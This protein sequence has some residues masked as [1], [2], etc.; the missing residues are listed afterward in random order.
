M[1]TQVNDTLIS[2]I[3]ELE[4]TD[5]QQLEELGKN[6]SAVQILE[7]LSL[8]ASK[9]KQFIEKLF[10]IFHSLPSTIFREILTT[11]EPEQYLLLTQEVL[12]EA[13]Q[14]HLTHLCHEISNEYR[15]LIKVIETQ[16]KILTAISIEDIGLEDIRASIEQIERLFNMCVHILYTINCALSLCWKTSRIDLIDNFSRLK[17]QYL[18][19]LTRSIG[20]PSGKENSSTGLWG[21]LEKRLNAVYAEYNDDDPA[22][23]ALV[24][25]SIWYLKDY[26]EVGLLPDIAAE[27][28]LELS[29]VEY[30]ESQRLEYRENLFAQV[31]N[32]LSKKGLHSLKDLKEKGIYSRKTLTDFLLIK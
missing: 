1:N 19:V 5:K 3:G 28:Q 12:I 17:E 14:H 6:L 26:W 29:S 13:I 30:T 10:A 27:S 9:D 23:E 24:A 4:L 20:A 7:V 2:K 22:L 8:A 31:K 25:L 15:L 32:N 18:L 21:L 16:E 11:A